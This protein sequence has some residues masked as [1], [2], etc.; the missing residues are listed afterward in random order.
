MPKAYGK[1]NLPAGKVDEGETLEEAAIREA[2]EEC[3]YEVELQRRLVVIH[4]EANRPVLHA[5]SAAIVGGEL[6]IPEDEILDAKWFTATEV[7]SMESDIRTPVY[8]LGALDAFE[9]Q[10]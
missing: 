6:N 10:D 9:K 3:G 7:R 4:T 2:R 1:W 8:V 5:F